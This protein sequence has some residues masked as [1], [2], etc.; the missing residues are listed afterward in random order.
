M[1]KRQ[2]VVTID[3]IGCKDTTVCA[4]SVSGKAR[5]KILSQSVTI[6]TGGSVEVT[7]DLDVELAQSGDTQAVIAKPPERKSE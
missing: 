5:R 6:E 2:L 3:G 1:A 4:E 7:F